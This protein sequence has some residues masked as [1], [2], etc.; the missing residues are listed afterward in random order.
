MKFFGCITINEGIKYI[1]KD[2]PNAISMH[3]L[4]SELCVKPNG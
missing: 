3:P 4:C 1:E 2:C